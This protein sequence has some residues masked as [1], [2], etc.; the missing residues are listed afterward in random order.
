MGA[1]V[2]PVG[3]IAVLLAGGELTTSN[4]M[5][6]SVA[7]IRK[8]IPLRKLLYNW[9]TV[10]LGNLIGAIFTAY[11]LGHITGIM[12]GDFLQTTLH[13]ASHKA[14]QDFFPALVS[15]IGC[16]IFV[17]L[18]AW[19]CFGAKDFTGKILGIWFPVMTFVAIGFQHVIANMFIIPAAMFSGA[20][21]ITLMDFFM[22]FVSVYIGNALGGAVFLGLFYCVIYGKT[23]K[24]TS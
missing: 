16:N 8:S 17:C 3:L 22:N 1:C 21:S 6:V 19:L 11:F 2:F 13:V 14:G 12:E 10:T 5:V 24:A 23:E 15:G 7:W 4:M 9:G 18:G 20:S